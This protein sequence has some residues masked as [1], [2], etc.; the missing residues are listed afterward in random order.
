M[1]VSDNEDVKQMA[2]PETTGEES[3]TK[4]I[5]NFF[6]ESKVELRKVT[7]PTKHE[8]V[9]DTVVVLIA[10]ALVAIA[11]WVADTVFSTVIWA[12]EK[13]IGMLSILIPVTR[14]RSVRTW[15]A[16]SIL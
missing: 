3:T 10:V 16:R 13:G 5:V 1:S 7:W 2:L 15:N 9:V 11:I 14:I 4:K 12:K 8:L 6:K